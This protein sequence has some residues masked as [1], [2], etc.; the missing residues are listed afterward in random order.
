TLSLQ[1]KNTPLVTCSMGS[2]WSKHLN[3]KAT[4]DHHHRLSHTPLVTSGELSFA[5][6]LPF[7]I[8]LGFLK[9]LLPPASSYRF[10]PP[11]S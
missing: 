4:V 7:V 2:D 11:T 9:E 6:L 3:L 5:S 8:L 1:Y 10:D